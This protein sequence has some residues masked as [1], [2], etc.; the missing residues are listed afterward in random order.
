[1]APKSTAPWMPSKT[2]MHSLSAK[3]F[4]GIVSGKA[5]ATDQCRRQKYRPMAA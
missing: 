1:M 3:P 4:A 2:G 5:A